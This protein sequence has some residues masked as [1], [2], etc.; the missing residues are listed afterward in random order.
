M[1]LKIYLRFIL[2]KML[3]GSLRVQNNI[4]WWGL[5]CLQREHNILDIAWLHETCLRLIVCWATIVTRRSNSFRVNR[6]SYGCEGNWWSFHLYQEWKYYFNV[7]NKNNHHWLDSPVWALSF[8]KSFLHSSLFFAVLN[9][10]VRLLL[11]RSR[12]SLSLTG[13]GC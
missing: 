4:I 7:C 10:S 13:W 2:F 9:R 11:F 1:P 5:C 12:K 6:I 3:L 8:F